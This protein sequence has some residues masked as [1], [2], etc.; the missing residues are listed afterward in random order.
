MKK[1]RELCR[2]NQILE[3]KDGEWP[4]HYLDFIYEDAS[5]DVINYFSQR[6]EY[7]TMT[8]L[9]PER[10]RQAYRS[11]HT[12][13][14]AMCEN[15][16]PSF[17][18]PLYF[19]SSKVRRAFGEEYPLQVDYQFKYWEGDRYKT[20]RI[21]LD[22]YVRFP[23]GY[24]KT[25]FNDDSRHVAI[26]TMGVYP[27]SHVIYLYSFHNYG[28][29]RN[30]GANPIET[31]AV[32]GLGKQL[33]YMS[34]QTIED[35]CSFINDDWYLVLEAS[36]E[37]IKQQLPTIEEAWKYLLQ[38]FPREY[39][40]CKND[41]VSEQQVRKIAS[42]GQGNDKLIAYYNKTYG[43]NIENMMATN[44][45]IMSAPLFVIKSYDPYR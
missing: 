30:H 4:I 16:E 5:V 12:D 39:L 45:T 15:H 35:F 23:V 36:G 25:A 19:N 3:I 7:K 31:E 11:G 10:V 18:V 1:F 33:L 6:Q 21:T 41:E 27:E 2:K 9:T 40:E 17:S 43:L 34:L 20:S 29:K 32:K 28:S 37:E 8:L 26:V 14:I 44:Y 22:S 13:V 38:K 24:P 42:I